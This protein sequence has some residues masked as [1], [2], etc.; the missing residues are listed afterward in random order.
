MRQAADGA[1]GGDLVHSN[2]TKQDDAVAFDSER[3]GRLE[4]ERG[5]EGDSRGG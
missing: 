3:D 1:E 2:I 4:K 5:R